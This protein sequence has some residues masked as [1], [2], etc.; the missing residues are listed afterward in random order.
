MMAVVVAGSLMM[1]GAFEISLGTLA[2]LLVFGVRSP[3][4]EPVIER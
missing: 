1:L 3:S 4:G 2:F